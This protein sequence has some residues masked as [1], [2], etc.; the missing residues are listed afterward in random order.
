MTEQVLVVETQ[1]LSLTES[2]YISNLEQVQSLL[3]ICSKNYRFFD[4]DKAEADP[5]YKQL[6]P[7]VTIISDQ[8]LC[9]ERTSAQSEERLHGKI[10]LGVG[11]HINPDDTSP[12]FQELIRKAMFRELTE[13]L[14]IEPTE[15]I[16]VGLINDQS[17][18]V[19]AVH[20]G[21]HYILKSAQRPLVRETD[22][23]KAL[24]CAPPQLAAL[25]PRM[26][27]WSQILLPKLSKW[28][29]L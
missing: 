25:R 5:S 8:V 9:L 2:R 1:R 16:L 13:E 12:N 17:N 18:P 3:D 22:K 6:I 24:W 4:R 28:S 14:W 29:C 15:P 7:Y 10:S 11:G 19:G 20:L 23:M 27:T 21:L 26:E